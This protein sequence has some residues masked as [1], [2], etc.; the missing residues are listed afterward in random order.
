MRYQTP[1]TI[2]ITVARRA[3][4]PLHEQIA[5]QVGSAVEHGLLG[6][7]AR[8]PSTRTL[9][10]LLGVSRG[11]VAAAYDLLLTRGY[12]DSQPGSGTY[13]TGRRGSHPNPAPR[14]RRDTGP[15]DL[16]PGQPS[17]E[18]FPLTA[19]RA[20]WRQAGFRRPP[21]HALP[22]LGLP[23]LRRAIA[24]HVSYTHG[25]SLAGK[26]VAVTG[27]TAHGLRIV[28]DALGLRGSQVAVEEP[29]PPA[30]HRA[31]GGEPDPPAALPV[32]ADGARV[33]AAPAACRAIVVSP[34]AQVPLGR[35]MSERRRREAAAWAASGGHVI[36]IA[37][38]LVFR[39]GAS[40]L[41]RLQVLAGEA[42]VLLGSFCEL[43]TPTLK[44][45]YAIIPREL[46]DLIGRRIADRAEQPP[47][48]AQCAVASLLQDGTV[49]RLVHRL[50][51]LRAGKRRLLDAAL[52]QLSGFELSGCAAVDTGVLHLPE[53]ADADRA[54]DA[55][56]ARGLRVAT[57]RPYH[58][59]GR[60]VPPALVLGYGHQPNAVLRRALPV[61]VEALD[62]IAVSSA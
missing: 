9:A 28:L 49:V 52:A 13:V 47:Y 2:P 43:L 19:W 61:L 44:L 27:G 3:G 45:G 58:F 46:T 22:P 34:D 38:N 5:I 11:V 33:D 50:G 4:R 16:R 32:D 17:L 21:A 12:L 60:P 24:D 41:P 37:S 40:P 54:A 6:A 23:E 56:L 14:R 15:V 55:L 57:L 62:Q 30:L 35:V 36:E 42:S 29:V 26:E 8:L 31:A 25:I 51:H 59:S 20:A 10:E 1:L 7:N 39:T 48:V 18:A 53:E